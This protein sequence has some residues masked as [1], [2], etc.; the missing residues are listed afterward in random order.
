MDRTA[1]MH[2]LVKF[3]HVSPVLVQVGLLQHKTKKILKHWIYVF[4]LWLTYCTVCQQLF[5]WTEFQKIGNILYTP[6]KTI[7]FCIWFLVHGN[8]SAWGEWTTCPGNCGSGF[9][10]RTR[11]CDN[12]A[13]KD[14]GRNCSGN[15]DDVKA[16][17]HTLLCDGNWLM[18]Y[19]ASPRQRAVLQRLLDSFFVASF[20]LEKI[21]FWCVYECLLM[22]RLHV[23]IRNSASK[24]TVCLQLFTR[25]RLNVKFVGFSY[26][27]FSIIIAHHFFSRNLY[28]TISFVIKSGSFCGC[29]PSGERLREVE[30]CILFSN[31]H[32]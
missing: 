1:V 10:N 32:C 21:W 16:C 30:F 17:N 13:P 5:S 20:I 27:M 23:A 11:K 3:S 15:T 26:L 6:V 9:V 19:Q 18:F 31:F 28:L 29:L 12:P 7:L 25:Y 22:P 14:G 4:S 8:W 24:R 2:L